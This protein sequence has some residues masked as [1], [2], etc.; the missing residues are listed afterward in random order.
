MVEEF[1][2][3]SSR[4]PFFQVCVVGLRSAVLGLFLLGA[5]ADKMFKEF[6]DGPVF[7]FPDGE[8]VVIEKFNF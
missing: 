1:L 6:E 4:F 7:D 8:P 5:L 2:C 3:L